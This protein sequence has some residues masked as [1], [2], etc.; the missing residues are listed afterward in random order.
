MTL[1]QLEYVIAVAEYKNFTLAAEK[2]FV[3]QPTLSMQIQKLEKELDIEIFD[4][5]AHPIQLTQIGEKVVQQAKIILKEA[6]KMPQ[7]VFEEKALLEGD[8][9]IGIIPTALPSLV[10]LFYKDF[11]KRHPKANIIIKEFQT[12]EI[13]SKLYEGSL[14]FGLVVT[15]L[16]EDQIVERKLYDEP[17]IAYIPAW[18]PLHRNLTIDSDDLSADEL[19]LLKEGHC[20]RNNVLSLCGSPKK[21]KKINLDSGSLDTLIQLAN[22]AYGITLLP[23]M[24]ADNLPKEFKKNLRN[25]REPIP[26]RS[27]SLIYHQSNLRKSFENKL[28]ETLQKAL[29]E[30]ITLDKIIQET[31]PLIS[32]S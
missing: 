3:T 27:I 21:S 4:R 32:L 18:H 26:T 17:M 15:P 14:D 12:S 7:L 29:K 22:D 30:K 19:L 11:Q 20:F 10:T 1:V 9:T 8:F 24:Y 28:F 16:N 25:F 5:S 6:G 31:S 23:S 13:I 2:S